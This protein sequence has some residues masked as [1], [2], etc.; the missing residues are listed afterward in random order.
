VD[1]LSRLDK[2]NLGR[3]STLLSDVRPG[4]ASGERR[5]SIIL[6]DVDGKSLTPPVVEGL[7]F[8]GLGR[9]YRPWLEIRYQNELANGE[10]VDL[11]G[12]RDEEALFKLLCDIL[13]PGSH[14][15][16]PY[17]THRI[18][19]MA[20]MFGVPPAASPL[21]YLMYMG[22][23]R[24]YK[25]WYFAEGFMEGEEKLQATKP[26]DDEKRRI[27]TV[28]IKDDLRAYL[29][30]EPDPGKPR[31]EAICRDLARRIIEMSDG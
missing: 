28:A 7:Y 12:T 23:C 18:T 6:R 16:V 24:W 15:M 31:M 11:E 13:P 29:F 22:G 30:R 2:R 8:E 5:F 25:D 21:G 26:L 9:W 20:L 4:R 14:I 19:A 3:F 10:M 17:R 1:Q 27:K